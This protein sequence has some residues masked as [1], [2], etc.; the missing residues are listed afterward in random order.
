VYWPPDWAFFRA[1]QLGKNVFGSLLLLAD[2]YIQQQ[3]AKPQSAQS[4]QRTHKEIHGDPPSFAILAS[5]RKQR[6]AAAGPRS[7]G[8]RV[9]AA[10]CGRRPWAGPSGIAAVIR[11]GEIAWQAIVLRGRAGRDHG[12]TRRREVEI[13][14][15]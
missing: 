1:L 6:W 9:Q 3:Q 15:G 14:K 7:C 11:A 10:A 13:R 2:N 4:S 8:A 5:Y 12:I